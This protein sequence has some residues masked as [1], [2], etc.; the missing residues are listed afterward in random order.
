LLCA[1][2]P[3]APSNPCNELAG[4]GACSEGVGGTGAC[5]CNP[6][7]IG[8][9]C[10]FSDATTCNGH[11]TADGVGGC[12]CQPGY[13]GA[14]CNQC[15]TNYVGYP[16]CATICGDVDDDGDV[17]A[18][19]ADAYRDFLADPFGATFTPGGA[20]KCAVVP[21][22]PG[23]PFCDLLDVVVLRRS[24]AAPPLAPGRAPV[25]DFVAP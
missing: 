20:S 22:A 8:G 21:Y 7:W 25:C 5:T 12:A 3:G 23:E 16:T 13:A 24:L 6:G 19:D 14:S 10:Q 2:C 11:G 1:P 17:T 4:G 9:G 18:A 15:A